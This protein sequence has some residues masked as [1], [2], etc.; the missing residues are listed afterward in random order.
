VAIAEAV[1]PE[2]A[3]VCVCSFRLG[4]EMGVLKS[5]HL[6]LGREYKS[7]HSSIDGSVRNYTSC[8][9]LRPSTC[10]ASIDNAS[11]ATSAAAVRMA[12]TVMIMISTSIV[13]YACT[14]QSVS[15]KAFP[16]ARGG[17]QPLGSK[18]PG[19]DPGVFVLPRL[20]RGGRKLLMPVIHSPLTGHSGY[21]RNP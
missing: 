5:G 4:G 17:D 7:T 13:F 11:D 14:S 12:A 3:L 9:L 10:I 19:V 2:D 16:T 20:G 15:A 6:Q 18:Y 8:D 1:V 21:V